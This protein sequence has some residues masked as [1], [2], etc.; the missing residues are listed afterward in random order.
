MTALD[1]ARTPAT[2]ARGGYQPGRLRAGALVIEFPSGDDVLRAGERVAQ[3]LLA[4]PGDCEVFID[5]HLAGEN[6]TVR[7]RTAQF[8]RVSPNKQLQEELV[9]AGV[10][11][12]WLE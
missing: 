11:V 9:A 6:L 2:A 8:A 4:H 5:L 10:L 12:R 1:R 3:T 7:A